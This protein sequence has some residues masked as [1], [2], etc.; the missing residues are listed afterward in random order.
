MVDENL[1]K[2]TETLWASDEPLEYLTGR[3]LDAETILEAQ[4]GYVADGRFMD[5]ISI[6]YFDAQGR[7]RSTRYRRLGQRA[8]R[9]KYDVERGGGHHLYNVA[10]ANE[11]RVAITEGEFDSLI[12]RQIGVPA[13]AV[14]GANA[15]D[16][17]WRWLFR[18]SD[19]V[20]VVTDD[21]AAGEKA[22]K[23]LLG[24]IGMITEVE[25]VE[26]PDGMDVTD[27]YLSDPHELRRLFA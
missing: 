21:D 9:Q 27:L 2:M 8:A 5:S 11:P 10:A 14:P 6:P 20:L 18:N 23:R 7:W 16:R 25:S 17:D 15:W 13:V 4:L 12:L 22:R 3:G 24:A 1:R 19:L 26:L